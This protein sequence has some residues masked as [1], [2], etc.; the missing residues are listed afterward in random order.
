MNHLP[1]DIQ[2]SFPEL[3]PLKKFPSVGSERGGSKET[4]EKRKSK[5]STEDLRRRHRRRNGSNH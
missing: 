4:E 5:F 1:E 2:P 3:V